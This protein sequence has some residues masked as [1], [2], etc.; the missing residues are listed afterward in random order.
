[1]LTLFVGYSSNT[2]IDRENITKVESKITISETTEEI[3]PVITY[4]MTNEQEKD[5]IDKIIDF[6][7]T[8]RICY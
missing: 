4:E 5:E 1:M 8:E 3:L 6:I 2:D 7:K